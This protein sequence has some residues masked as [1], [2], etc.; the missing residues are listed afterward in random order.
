M[1][2]KDL[3]QKTY[4]SLCPKPYTFPSSIKHSIHTQPSLTY[5]QI[6]KQNLSVPTKIENESH[7]NLLSPRP[8]SPPSI[9]T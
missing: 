8:Q 4:P 9:S 2:Y 7:T 1:V 3:Q 5:T 6:T